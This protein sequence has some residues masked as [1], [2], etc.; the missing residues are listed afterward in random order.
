MLLHNGGYSFIFKVNKQNLYLK[1]RLWTLLDAFAAATALVRV[2]SY[3]V[4]A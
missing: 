3:V 1:R 4:I 2:D